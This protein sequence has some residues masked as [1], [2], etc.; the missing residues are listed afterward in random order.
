MTSA[1]SIGCCPADETFTIRAGALFL[2]SGN[3]KQREQKAGE[4]I[5]R[6][7]QLE[8]LGVGLTRTSGTDSSIVDQ[9]VE[10]IHPRLGLFGETTHLGKCR[11][12]GRKEI[13]GGPVVAF[14]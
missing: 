2:I 14:R 3:S 5:D 9:D 11:E 12:V 8:P 7:P 13:R 6:K 4:V 1:K 10:P